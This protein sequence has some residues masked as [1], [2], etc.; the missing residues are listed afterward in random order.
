MKI[1]IRTLAIISMVLLIT[2]TLLSIFHVTP[3]EAG[4][5]VR[6]LPICGGNLNCLISHVTLV[7]WPIG[8]LLAIAIAAF[9]LALQTSGVRRGMLLLLEGALIISPVLVPFLDGNAVSVVVAS[10]AAITALTVLGLSLVSEP[11]SA[12]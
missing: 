4:L 7:L 6:P 12:R 8:V 2:P 1:A 9:S 3:Y 10:L 5:P 11:R